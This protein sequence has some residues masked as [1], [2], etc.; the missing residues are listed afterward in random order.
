MPYEFMNTGYG[1]KIKAKLLEGGLLKYAILFKNEKEIF[2]EAITTVV[3]LLCEKDDIFQGVSFVPVRSLDECSS[4]QSILSLQARHLRYEDL[5]PAQKWGAL[6]EESSVC[7]NAS[8]LTTF[9]YYGAFKRGIAT[10]ANEFFGLTRSKI[11]ALG[12][13][14]GSYRQ[15]ITKSFQIK[16]EVFSSEDL[17]ALMDADSPVF[18]LN[19]HDK[20]DPNVANYIRAGEIEGYH[21][22]YLTKM[23][24]PWYRLE[25]REPAPIWFGVFSRGGYKIVRNH[26]LALNL[27]CFHGFYPNL[28][29]AAYLDL[30]FLYLKSKTGQLLLGQNQRKYGGDL[31]KFEPNDLNECFAPTEQYFEKINTE[32]VQQLLRAYASQ[33]RADIQGEIDKI[34]NSLIRS[35]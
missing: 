11:D 15:C 32:L 30:L 7:V 27:T 35:S 33:E 4:L 24:N 12:L 28:W 5:N 16:K 17:D 2:P 19:A 18:I 29:G 22:R 14:E 34:F 9:A 20:N 8:S 6:F 26:T 21:E 1:K 31:D 23:R 25:V 3:V 13:P 10:G